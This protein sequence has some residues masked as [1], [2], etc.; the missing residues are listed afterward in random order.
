[1]YSEIRLKKDGSAR[2]LLIFPGGNRR[3]QAALFRYDVLLF[4]TS[5]SF[6]LRITKYSG[7]IILL[8]LC[9]ENSKKFEK[10]F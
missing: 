9:N 2:D 3:S 10:P 5:V 7:Y 6:R 8:S 4:S 1:M